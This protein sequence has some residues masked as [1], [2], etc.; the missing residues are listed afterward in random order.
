MLK[1]RPSTARLPLR[2]LMLLLTVAAKLQ[3]LQ[4]FGSFRLPAARLG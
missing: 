2:R 4:D 1:N 3:S